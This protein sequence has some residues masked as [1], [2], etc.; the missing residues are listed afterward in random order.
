LA[1]TQHAYYVLHSHSIPEPYYR[2]LLADVALGLVFCCLC[3]RKPMK[4]WQPHHALWLLLQPVEKVDCLQ[5][6]HHM[7]TFHTG[8]LYMV[9]AIWHHHMAVKHEHKKNQ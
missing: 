2:V 8:R 5:N 3:S 9:N 4:D 6:T 7:N 1:A